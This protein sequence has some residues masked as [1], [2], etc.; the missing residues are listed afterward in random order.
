MHPAV[1]GQINGG[2]LASMNTYIRSDLE[3]TVT[4]S[5]FENVTSMDATSFTKGK[6]GISR[7]E[8]NTVRHFMPVNDAG[9]GQSIPPGSGT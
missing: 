2:N 9:G 4:I 5:N 7:W 6:G 1:P 3:P 8:L